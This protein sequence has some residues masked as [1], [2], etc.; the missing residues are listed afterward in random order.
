MY[1]SMEC[2]N[3]YNII[4]KT[5]LQTVNPENPIVSMRV[6]YV[7]KLNELKHKYKASFIM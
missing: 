1:G 7:T 5:Y 3:K 2:L 4:I 6:G